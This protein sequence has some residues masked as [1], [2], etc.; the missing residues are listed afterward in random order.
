MLFTEKK[1][2]D[3]VG[4]VGPDGRRKVLKTLAKIRQFFLLYEQGK[5]R[6]STKSCQIKNF[7]IE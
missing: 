4:L 5:W 2:I 1:S 7:K 6:K 3:L